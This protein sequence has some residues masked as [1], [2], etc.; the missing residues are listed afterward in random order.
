[1]KLKLKL[2]LIAFSTVAILTSTILLGQTPSQIRVKVDSLGYLLVSSAAQTPPINTVTF[3]NARLRVDANGNLLVAGNG[4]S[5]FAPANAT[6]I[7]QTANT[8]LSA[9]QA[10]GS[11]SSGIL[12]G[13]AT[14]GVI[15]SL[16]DTLPAA[17][18]GTGVSNA[19]QTYTP[20]LTSITNLDATTA[21]TTQYMRVGN[22]VT[23][24]GRFD[25]D[26][27]AI[28]DTNF[29][30]SLP[31]ASAIASPEQAGGTALTTLSAEGVRI[32]ADLA[33]DTAEFRW[34]TVSTTNRFY[35]FSFTYLIVP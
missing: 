16:G 23:V 11:L 21:Y 7:V 32:A 2:K 33:T 35:S 10:I 34:T 18:G 17:N 31:I 14:T 22:V 3:N 29:H 4:S 1:M 28:G 8:G 12:R 27:T 19:T 9:E 5:G 13:A 20:T 6:Y 24:S 30:M 26:P 25:A 15:T